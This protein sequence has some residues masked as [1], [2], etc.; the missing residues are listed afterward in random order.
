MGQTLQASSHRRVSEH[1]LDLDGGDAHGN[2][3]NMLKYR[4]RKSCNTIESPMQA[5]VNRLYSS[6]FKKKEMIEKLTQKVQKDR[7]ITFQPQIT[8]YRP[9]SHTQSLK[10][11][12][13][14]N[15]FSAQKI[16]TGGA[17]F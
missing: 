16:A 6:V 17:G 14:S 12:I 11:I 9:P 13:E 10:R 7:G 2:A 3:V 8:E 4:Q 1:V 15:N 5:H